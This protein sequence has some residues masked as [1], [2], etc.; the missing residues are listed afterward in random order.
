MKTA[1]ALIAA[2][3]LLAG[4]TSGESD[5]APR[6]APAPGGTS[7]APTSAPDAAGVVIDVVLANGEVTPRG[8]RVEVKAGD[9][10]TLMVSSDV[11][12][13]LHVHAD[14]ERTFEV[15]AGADGA[16]FTFTVD[17]PG[18]VAVEAHGLDA[19]I[20]QLVVRP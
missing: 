10:V 16:T 15:D 14:P 8:G 13:E 5:G 6:P 2:V 4:C 18:Q 19:T 1:V 20:V 17:T 9:P 7:S 11:D 12:E 3:V